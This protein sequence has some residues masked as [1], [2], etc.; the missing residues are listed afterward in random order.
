MERSAYEEY[1]CEGGLKF[2]GH[3]RLK[4]YEHSATECIKLIKVFLRGQTAESSVAKNLV[5]E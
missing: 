2:R 4:Y 5:L 3:I 1:L